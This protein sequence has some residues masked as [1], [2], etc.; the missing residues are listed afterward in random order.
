[1][2]VDS[3]AERTSAV[4]VFRSK[5]RF[6]KKMKRDIDKFKWIAQKTK[7]FVLPL[8]RDREKERTGAAVDNDDDDDNDLD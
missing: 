3:R 5:T 4:T 7:T 2:F 6:D 8:V 1:M